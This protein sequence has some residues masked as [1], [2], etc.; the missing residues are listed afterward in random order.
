MRNI[1]LT[2]MRVPKPVRLELDLKIVEYATHKWISVRIA[3]QDL[4][5]SYQRHNV[6]EEAAILPGR[7]RCAI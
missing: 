3:S 6:F 4:L 2:V 7:E 5:L 1:S